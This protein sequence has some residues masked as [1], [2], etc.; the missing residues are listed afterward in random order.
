M[1]K[2][3]PLH[4]EEVL[5]TIVIY[6]KK[7]RQS[8]EYLLEKYEQSLKH[9]T[10]GQL[11]FDRQYLTAILDYRRGNPLPKA[12]DIANCVGISNTSGNVFKK[13]LLEKIFT[14]IEEQNIL[15]P[16]YEV[17]FMIKI[18]IEGDKKTVHRIKNILFRIPFLRHNGR[19]IKEYPR[20]ERY[21]GEIG[22]YLDFDVIE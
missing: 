6:N 16:A 2:N 22:I 5:F 1:V 7:V 18:R 13:A 4:T 21:K 9:T 14:M 17:W 15:I 3:D 8:I 12:E 11:E 10:V 19:Q 20:S